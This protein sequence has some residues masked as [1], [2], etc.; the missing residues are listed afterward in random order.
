MELKEYVDKGREEL[1]K[2]S[3]NDIQKETARVWMG[4]ACAAM[5]VGRPA[6]A[7]EYAHESI[8]HAALSGDNV[9]LESIRTMLK[10]YG[11]EL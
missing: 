1:L 4:R 10:R 2:K 6:D 3:L 9:L 11:A 8:E 7:K 5:L